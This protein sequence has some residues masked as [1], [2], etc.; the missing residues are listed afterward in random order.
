MSVQFPNHKVGFG[1]CKNKQLFQKRHLWTQLSNTSP[2]IRQYDFRFIRDFKIARRAQSNFLPV[3]KRVS[4][5]RALGV[6][7]DGKWA[8]IF[9]T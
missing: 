3:V 1:S 4:V 9:T 7:I 5:F 2:M 8:T 6:F